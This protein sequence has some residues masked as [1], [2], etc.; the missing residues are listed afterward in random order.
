MEEIQPPQHHN[1]R[2]EI[3]RIDME[4]HQNRKRKLWEKMKRHNQ[5]PQ[6]ETQ[7]KEELHR[8]IEKNKNHANQT[9]RRLTRPKQNISARRISGRKQTANGINK[10]QQ[11][12]RRPR[13]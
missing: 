4:L 12:I 10:F 11:I 9:T 6:Y 7:R 13:K 5:E 3:Q 1:H 2:E 8:V